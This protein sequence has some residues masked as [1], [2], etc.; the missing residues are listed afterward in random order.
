MI[1]ALVPPVTIGTLIATPA[2]MTIWLHKPGLYNP[3]VCLL[4][5]L[6]SGVMG[7]KEHK[8][9]FQ[10]CSNQHALLARLMFWSYIVM[11]VVAVPAIHFFGILGFL[12]D[13]FCAELFQVLAIL[14][15][16][17]ELFAGTSRLDF[18]PVYKLFALM[19]GATLLGAWLALTAGQRSVPHIALSAILFISF[20]LVISYPLF[21]LQ[22]VRSYLRNRVAV[23]GGR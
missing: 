22:E 9:Q 12:G 21:G 8:Y 14:R 5:A 17:Q 16:N 19:G 4:M 3:Y 18:S 15:L 6:I 1:F 11:V 7:I 20:L 10:T 2:L 13:W 23:V